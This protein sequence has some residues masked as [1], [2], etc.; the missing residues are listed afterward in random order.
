MNFFSNLLKNCLVSTVV[1]TCHAVSFAQPVFRVDT[2]DGRYKGVLIGVV[3]RVVPANTEVMPLLE[4][5]I[6]RGASLIMEQKPVGGWNI[7]LEKEVLQLHGLSLA[8]IIRKE[9]LVCL[10]K[11]EGEFTKISPAYASMYSTGPAAY[12]LMIAQPRAKYLPDGLSPNNV[13]LEKWLYEKFQSSTNQKITFLEQHIDV[14]ERLKKFSAYELAKIS[15]NYCNLVEAGLLEK[16]NAVLDFQRLLNLY[17]K[18]DFDGLKTY[19]TDLSRAVGWP[20]K[21]IKSQYDERELDF[22]E[23]IAN[24]L[25][26]S[27]N[28][29]FIITIGAAHIG[30]SSGVLASLR[31]RGFKI[32]QCN[33]GDYKSCV[34]ESSTN[35]Q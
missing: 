8:E 16:N 2:E 15:D 6:L 26:T 13:V 21:L 14:F 12:V 25:R 35:L 1:L 27:K 7:D 28:E 34:A 22:A 33:A 3:H 19:I 5:L 24:R 17:L 9:K 29:N 18:G 32:T 20:D 23:K 30:G 31:K 4:L 10:Q 11:I